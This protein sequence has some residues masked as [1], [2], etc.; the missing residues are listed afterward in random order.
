MG[1]QL[2]GRGR[3]TTVALYRWGWG[4]VSPKFS[5]ENQRSSRDWPKTRTRKTDDRL[6]RKR[7]R[8]VD[9]EG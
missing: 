6:K 5:R 2:G 4:P 1:E 9:P 8:W 7:I 3:R